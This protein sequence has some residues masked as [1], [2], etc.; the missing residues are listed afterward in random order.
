MA[1]PEDKGAWDELVS[2]L[3]QR[4]PYERKTLGEMQAEDFLPPT[5][6]SP[7]APDPPILGGPAELSKL[8]H[9][10]FRRAPNLKSH[11]SKI[12]YGP[13]ADTIEEFLLNEKGGGQYFPPSEFENTNLLG[14]YSGR[15]DG[16][17]TISLNPRLHHNPDQMKGTLVHE[18]A[19]AGAKGGLRGE[20]PSELAKQLYFKAEG[21]QDP[22]IKLKSQMAE[23]MK[24]FEKLG[25][26]V[27]VE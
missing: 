21:V 13:T 27:R 22:A 24:A 3:S 2:L 14:L 11:V 12:Q 19:H 9:E 10:L 15:G 26:K 16:S 25:A 20:G 18:L 8:A 17:E 6:I 23:M 1:G 5:P 7:F 4:A